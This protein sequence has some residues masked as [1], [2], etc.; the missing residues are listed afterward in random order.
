M[1]GSPAHPFYTSKPK[2]EKRKKKRRCAKES[3][4][5]V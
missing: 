1:G 2:K 3:K 5:A 4:T